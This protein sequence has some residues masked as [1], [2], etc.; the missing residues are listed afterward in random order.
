[1]SKGSFGAYYRLRPFSGRSN[2]GT[3][4][5]PAW[6][7]NLIAN[8]R[9]QIAKAGGGPTMMATEVTDAAERDRLWA[10]AD[11]I[12]PLYADYRQRAS[13]RNR[14]VPIIRLTA[15]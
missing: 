9:V 13:T 4:K 5:H 15:A 12:Y 6:Y 14:I 1:V 8:P 2:Y 11:R 7:H 3:E 10:L